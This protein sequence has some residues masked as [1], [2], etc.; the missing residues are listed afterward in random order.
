MDSTTTEQVSRIQFI[1]IST[2]ID[3]KKNAI[4]SRGKT[5]FP[6]ENSELTMEI[7][8]TSISRSIARISLLH[9]AAS[10]RTVRGSFPK[11]QGHSIS[12]NTRSKGLSLALS[13]PHPFPIL[14]HA[15]SLPRPNEHSS[16]PPDR[17]SV[18]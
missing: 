9:N 5:D 17:K 7:V 13:I 12:V 2:G 1:F 16:T 3:E 10:L 4:D 8:P 14:P 18:V 11:G 6:T 15:Q